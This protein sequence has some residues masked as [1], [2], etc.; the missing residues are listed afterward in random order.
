MNSNIFV[1]HQD[2]VTIAP[3]IIGG[4]MFL[5]IISDKV[6]NE[7]ILFTTLFTIGVFFGLISFGMLTEG[8][9]VTLIH[10]SIVTLYSIFRNR[11]KECS[12]VSFSLEQ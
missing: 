10:F 4:L 5:M 7:I 2:C 12:S 11:R 3:F 9:I 6:K 8:I 1:V